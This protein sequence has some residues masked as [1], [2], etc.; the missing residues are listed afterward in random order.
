MQKKIQQFLL[1]N[2]SFKQIIVKN[3]FW[4]FLAEVVSKWSIAILIILI[5]RFFWKEIFWQRSY[6]S[7]ILTFL[8]I[9]ADLGITQLTVRDR[10]HLDTTTRPAWLHNGLIIKA[11]LSVGV[12]I[13]YLGI[14]R[15]QANSTFLWIIW[16]VLLFQGI[17]NSFLEYLRATFRSI[18]RSEVETMIKFWQ[19]IGNLLLIPLL[20]F[21]R[22]LSLTLLG[23]WFITVITCVYA[24]WL[25]HKKQILVKSDSS[26]SHKELIQKGWMFAMSGLFVSMYYYVD[27][28]MIKWYWWYAEVGVYNAAYKLITLL[29]TPAYL[30]GSVCFPIFRSLFIDN[31]QKFKTYTKKLNITLWTTSLI[32]FP[33]LIRQSEIIIIQLYGIEYIPSIPLLQILLWSVRIVY[34]YNNY[35]WWLL[36]INQKYHTISTVCWLILNIVLNV[37]F[38]PHYWPTGAAIT[39]LITEWFICISLLFFFKQQTKTL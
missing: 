5:G 14:L 27:S 13:V 15:W 10:Q 7:T 12:V 9:F 23:Q 34:L 31:I 16:L 11:F 30:F 24:R 25:I 22:S 20:Y 4:L 2:T 19:W 8:I 36:A 29:I 18:Q 33:L 38:I 35:S 6:L 32:I 1:A 17:A 37:I 21:S 39:T 3:T 28:L 26:I